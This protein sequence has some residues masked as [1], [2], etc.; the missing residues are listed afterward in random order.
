MRQLGLQVVRLELSWSL[1]EPRPGVYDQAYL[2]R[3]EQVVG[4][5]AEEGVYVLLDMHQNAYSRYVGRADPARLPLPGGT[6][7]G[8]NPRT[9]PSD[10]PAPSWFSGRAP[11]ASVARR[12]DRP[13]R[14]LAGGVDPVPRTRSRR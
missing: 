5:A 12:Y 9:E 3:I 14:N 7:V 1:L 2:A 10:G 11:E 6:A 4:W 13:A 8:L